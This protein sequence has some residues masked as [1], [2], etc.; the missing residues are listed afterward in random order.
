MKCH[1]TVP[2]SHIPACLTTNRNVEVIDGRLKGEIM[3]LSNLN[4]N[5]SICMSCNQSRG[6]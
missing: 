5:S 4:L 1:I 2:W 6:L 3:G